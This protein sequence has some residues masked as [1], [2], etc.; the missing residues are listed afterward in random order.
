MAAGF[1][2]AVAGIAG[3]ASQ[4]KSDIPPEAQACA[5]S[6]PPVRATDYNE[7]LA[8]LKL[9]AN[10]VAQCMTSHGLV[11]DEGKLQEELLHEEWVRNSNVMGSDPLHYLMLLEQELRASPEMWRR[12]TPPRAG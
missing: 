5:N 2:V 1:L 10:T 6:V 11:L 12:G 9:R 4:G 3:C 8:A 7:R